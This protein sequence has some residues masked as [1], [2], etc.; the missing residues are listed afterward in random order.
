[1]M[2]V[3]PSKG[4]YLIVIAGPTAVGK[5]KI[6]VS[7]A[8][9]MNADIISADSRQFYKEIKIGTAAPTDTELC[10]AKH[11]FVGQLS[12]KEEY[13]V[14]RYEK[15][16]IAFLDSYF[17]NKDYALLVG[18]SGL[19]IDAVC[20]G[21]DDLPDPDPVL[22]KNLIQLYE[23]KGLGCLQDELRSLDPRAL[24][25]IDV[26]NP[27]RIFRAIE[28]C[29]STGK[30]YSGFV[31]KLPK[32]RDFNILKIALFLDR[33]V[34]FDRINTR[35]DKM[36]ADGLEDEARSLLPYR[37]FNSLNTVGYKELFSYFDGDLD[38]TT[39]IE[40]IK[41][42]T[43]RYAKRQMVWFQKDKSFEW[44]KPVRFQAILDF[45]AAN[46]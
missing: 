14:H 15:D 40:K 43:R 37:H 7:L 31:S 19:F 16:V 12:V 21:I 2:S 3:K 6:G 32:Q 41:T 22:R 38:Y 23:S 5:T 9:A 28:I 30:P 17:R 25:M 26:A 46:T 13:N 10:E 42:H 1:M 8:Q 39:A 34:L 33:D 29:K 27:K 11:H 20:R 24:E 35:V 45:I 36:L 4:K 44:F 18:G